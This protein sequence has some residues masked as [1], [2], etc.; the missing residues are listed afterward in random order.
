MDLKIADDSTHKQFTGVSNDCILRNFDNL[1]KSGKECCIRTPL[2]PGITDN[3]KNLS[4]IKALVGDLHHEL[5]PYN[6]VGEAKYK[7]L[8]MSYP[9]NELNVN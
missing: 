9:M 3:E 2:I 5:L 4:E 1:R 8:N 7:M 6:P